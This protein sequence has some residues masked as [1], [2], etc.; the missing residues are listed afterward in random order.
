MMMQRIGSLVQLGDAAA[1]DW[2]DQHL[3]I[4]VIHVSINP[5]PVEGAETALHP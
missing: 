5:H 4:V 2:S 1:G 3:K